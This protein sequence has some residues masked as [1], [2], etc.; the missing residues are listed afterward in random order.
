M[1]DRKRHISTF[2]GTFGTRKEVEI[3]TTN[4]INGS[5]PQAGAHEWPAMKV[6]L[7]WPVGGEED[8]TKFLARLSVFLRN[9]G[10]PI[11]KLLHY[12]DIPF[13]QY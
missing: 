11:E 1:S 12:E 10:F 5:G 8:R 4:F 13:N 7:S 3:E 2:S 6:R 9:E